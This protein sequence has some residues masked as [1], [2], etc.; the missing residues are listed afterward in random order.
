MSAEQVFHTSGSSGAPRQWLRSR[1]QME[2]EARLIYQRWA[3]QVSEI[4]S[5]APVS[6]SYGQILG[7][8][9]ASVHGAALQLDR[10]S[11]V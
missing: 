3:P 5:F 6:H 2:Q 4:I 10:K 9:G 1:A 7:E 8:T 11:V